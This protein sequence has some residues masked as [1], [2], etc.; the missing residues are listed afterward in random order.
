MTALKEYKLS[1]FNRLKNAPLRAISIGCIYFL[2][3]ERNAWN[4]TSVSQY[5][6]NCIHTD[7]LSA[8]AE[9]ERQRGSG[10]VFRIRQMPALL[11]HSDDGIAVVTEI[12]TSRP[13]HGLVV[14]QTRTAQQQAWYVNVT[15]LERLISPKIS[16]GELIDSLKNSEIFWRTPPPLENG[17]L[18]FSYFD[19]PGLESLTGSRLRQW[20]SMS[21]GSEYDLNWPKEWAKLSASPTRRI[22]DALQKRLD[23]LADS[24]D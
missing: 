13:L 6:E 14:K 12:N 8:K 1:R 11:F 24:G 21:V 17:L 5:S 2:V 9:A 19:N 16:I 18:L 7:L 3:R 15:H 4:W 10:S 23:L 20:K 22:A